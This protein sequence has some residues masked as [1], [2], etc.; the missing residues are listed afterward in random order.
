MQQEAPDSIP[1]AEHPQDSALAEP[2]VTGER[3]A[4]EEA[5]TANPP[6]PPPELPPGIPAPPIPKV[7][8]GQSTGYMQRASSVNSDLICRS[9]SAVL[10]EL[11]ASRQCPC[12]W[13]GACAL[14]TPAFLGISQQM[15]LAPPAGH[16]SSARARA[17]PPACG[18]Q[19]QRGVADHFLAH[20]PPVPAWG[21]PGS[22]GGCR[23]G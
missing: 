7:S 13:R 17:W 2:P 12:A 10:S 6:R 4:A 19:A 9:D 23:E 22:G 16:C 14:F 15:L 11:C 20:V 3:E 21:S 18:C 1:D 8:I 5:R